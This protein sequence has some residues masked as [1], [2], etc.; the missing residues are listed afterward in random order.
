MK[1]TLKLKYPVWT[2]TE[3]E[4]EVDIPDDEDPEDWVEI[5][6]EVLL[7]DYTDFSSNELVSAIDLGYAD[8]WL[9]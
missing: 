6:K 2:T 7:M 9:L 1:R 4:I 3:K 5:N 8:V